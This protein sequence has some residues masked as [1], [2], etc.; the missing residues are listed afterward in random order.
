MS[1]SPI[2]HSPPNHP[3]TQITAI[4]AKHYYNEV[5]VIRSIT[6][7]G[8]E[9]VLQ[10]SAFVHLLELFPTLV[11][12]S[13]PKLPS[14]PPNQLFVLTFDFNKLNSIFFCLQTQNCIVR[15][16]WMS[17][18][19]LS[20]LSADKINVLITQLQQY[21]LGVSFPFHCHYS[22]S[23]RHP[24]FQDQLQVQ[25]FMTVGPPQPSTILPYL[26]LIS[27]HITYKY[28]ML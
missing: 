11:C 13:K 7:I 16:N 27:S 14:C 12:I 21:F 23:D 4:K 18:D 24:L 1:V 20:P 22:C 28:L 25:P 19:N 3:E 8:N 10:G 17:P 6:Q 15:N 26:R 9:R 5:S 2:P